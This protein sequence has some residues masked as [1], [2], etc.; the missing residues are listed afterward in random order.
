M[1]NKRIVV[2]KSSGKRSIPKQQSEKAELGFERLIADAG[3]SKKAAD[4]IMKWYTT[5]K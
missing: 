3:S 4:E 1:K 5:S 2:T